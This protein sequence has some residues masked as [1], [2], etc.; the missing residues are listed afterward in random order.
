MVGSRTA[1][2]FAGLLVSLAI[3]VGVYL[4]TGWLFAFLVVP[5]VPFLFTRS[6]RE[7]SD[8]VPPTKRCPSCDFRTRDPSHEYCPRDGRRLRE[9]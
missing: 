5:F 4:A 1:T 8:G 3:S 9:E 7:S 6:R 2:A